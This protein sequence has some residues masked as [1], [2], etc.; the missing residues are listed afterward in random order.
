MAAVLKAENRETKKSVLNKL[1]RDGFIPAVLYGD[2]VENQPIS[3]EEKVFSKVYREVGRSGVISLEL[4]NETHPVMVYDLQIDPIKNHVVHADFLKVDMNVEVDAEI[5]VQLVGKA[6]G[7]KEGG[8]VQHSLY[9]LNIR[10]LPA[11]LPASIE[12]SLD[13]LNIGDSIA[14]SDLK[15]GADYT[16]LNDDEE[17]IVSVLAPSEEEPETTDEAPAEE[18]VEEGEENSEE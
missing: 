16:I 15:D 7:E 11:N 14:V 3:V 4:Q 18:A 8:I 2:D 5:P 1:R 6:P 9:T 17:V 12:V 10:A 13:D